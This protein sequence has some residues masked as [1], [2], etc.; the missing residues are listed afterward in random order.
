MKI[1]V[2]LNFMVISYEKASLYDDFVYKT[3]IAWACCMGNRADGDY[4]CGRLVLRQE[5]VVVQSELQITDCIN[6][7]G[8]II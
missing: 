7:I 3:R 6:Y 8:M 5:V 1:G 4:I 2:F